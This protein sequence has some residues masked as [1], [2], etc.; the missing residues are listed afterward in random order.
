MYYYLQI[1]PRYLMFYVQSTAKGHIRAKVNVLLPHKYI[2]DS[3]SMTHS[4]DEDRRSLGKNE[5]E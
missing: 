1:A 4:T 5:V 3:L 2:A